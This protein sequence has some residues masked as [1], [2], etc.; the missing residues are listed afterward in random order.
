MPEDYILTPEEIEALL[1]NEDFVD[2]K[3]DIHEI[4]KEKARAGKTSSKSYSPP[5]FS[6]LKISPPIPVPL[7]QNPLM[8]LIELNLD[9]SLLVSIEIAPIKMSIRHWLQLNKGD[10]VPLEYLS[11]QPLDIR[12]NG[13]VVAHGELVVIDNIPKIKLTRV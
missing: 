13:I 1:S 9:T 2:I 7:D 4:P 11:H 8:D 5:G 3:G 12:I 10:I 6:E